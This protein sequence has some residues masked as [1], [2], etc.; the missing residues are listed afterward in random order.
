M[1][2]AVTVLVVIKKTIKRKGL[3]HLLNAIPP[4]SVIGEAAEGGEAIRMARESNPAVILLDQ[5]RYETDGPDFLRRIWQ[6]NPRTRLLV[7]ANYSLEEQAGLDS[8]SG[9]L[10][11]AP[12]NTEPERLAQLIQEISGNGAEPAGKLPSHPLG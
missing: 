12:K 6:D 8:Q 7:L 5:E 4:I 3:S 10:R 1:A 2:E 11:F 9:T